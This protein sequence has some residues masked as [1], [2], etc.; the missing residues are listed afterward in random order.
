MELTTAERETHLNLVA[1]DRN[2]WHC[3]SDD[4]IM[5]RRLESIGATITKRE[6]DGVG[7]HYTLRAD[8]V[9][10]R[11]GKRKSAPMTEAQLRNLQEGRL[12]GLRLGT[13][14]DADEETDE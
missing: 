3:Y 10:L 7:I 11:K 2:I 1:D 6:K 4:P 8:Q 12:S 13:S 5:Q 9:F 14:Q